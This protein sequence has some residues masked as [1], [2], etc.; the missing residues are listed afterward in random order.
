MQ[1]F[2]C[3][4]EKVYAFYFLLRAME[5][6]NCDTSYYIEITHFS[7]GAVTGLIRQLTG[8]LDEIVESGHCVR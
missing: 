5:T 7:Q 4:K 2:C 8:D 6:V 3:L 1:N